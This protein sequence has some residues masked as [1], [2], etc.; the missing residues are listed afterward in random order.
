M[1]PTISPSADDRR[2][3]RSYIA[4]VTLE[5]HRRTLTTALRPPVLDAVAAGTFTVGSLIIGVS[6]G[7]G[8]GY[9]V[10]EA[11]V[12]LTV[13]GR[14]RRPVLICTV[15]LGAALIGRAL[16]PPGHNGVGLIVLAFLL[17]F[18]FLGFAA[19]ARSWRHRVAP[20]ALVSGLLVLEALLDRNGVGAGLT[21]WTIFGGLPFAAGWAVSTRVALADAL[22]EENVWIRR[23]QDERLASLAREERARIA[24]ELHD[25]VAHSMT[26][27]VVQAAAARSVADHDQ[28]A[29]MN[30]LA[31][32]EQCGR[33][34]LTEM[35]HLVSVLQ[36]GV[37]GEA[38][39]G[40]ALSDVLG[41]VE[42]TRATGLPVEFELWG[43][44]REVPPGVDLAAYRVVQEALTNAVK[45]AGPATV[46]VS[47]T[48]SESTLAVEVVDDG[49][50][51]D[52]PKPSVDGGRGL[53]GMR[54]RVELY[55]GNLI[56]FRRG[57]GAGF[58]VRAE[59]PIGGAA[60]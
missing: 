12:G 17:D 41:L 53:V 34:G 10:A 52:P 50:R 20:L 16:Q 31:T 29:A 2:G 42:R 27:M 38:A 49:R 24:R 4:R 14:R 58:L 11:A 26:V 32:V 43:A 37:A 30:A 47:V 15:A 56:A 9:I 23:E 35:R 33:K 40:G 5:A 3:P 22:S 21:S 13:L 7:G 44:A 6:Q 59:L 36:G 54:E 45:H 39:G 25:I 46:R 51:A 48:Y 18:Y 55:G 57:E 1:Y 19:Q 8:P 28:V 60:P